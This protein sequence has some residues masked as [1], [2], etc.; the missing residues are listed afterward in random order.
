MIDNLTIVQIS[1]APFESDPINTCCK[2]SRCYDEYDSIAE[3]V[4]K[5]LQAGE[6]LPKAIKEE[7]GP[8]ALWW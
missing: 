2:G 8:L 1:K 5:R 7:V 3:A 4:S 6:S